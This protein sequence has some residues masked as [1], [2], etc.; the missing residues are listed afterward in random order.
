VLFL[1]DEHASLA[2]AD[3]FRARP[4]DRLWLRPSHV[5]PTVNL[6]HR[7]YAIRGDDVVAVWPVEARDY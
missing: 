5:D 2:V 6:H 3:G 4:G 7:L 1:S